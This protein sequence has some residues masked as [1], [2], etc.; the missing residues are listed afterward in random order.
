MTS[1]TEDKPSDPLDMTDEEIKRRQRGR[2]I[3]V[4]WCVVAFVVIVF[5]VSIVRIKAGVEAGLGG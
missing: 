2:N 3:A 4:A 5:T 1:M